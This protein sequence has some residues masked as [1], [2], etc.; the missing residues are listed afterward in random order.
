MTDTE[1]DKAFLNEAQ[2]NLVNAVAELTKLSKSAGCELLLRRGRPK[3]D[4]NGGWKKLPL[5][6]DF[7]LSFRRAISDY[8]TKF[9]SVELTVLAYGATAQGERLG[10]APRAEL[11]EFFEKLPDRKAADPF[12]PDESD[13]SSQDKKC[14]HIGLSEA[15]TLSAFG[16]SGTSEIGRYARSKFLAIWNSKKEVDYPKDELLEIGDKVTFFVFGNFVYVID[17]SGFASATGY[18]DVVKQ[19]S[20]Q[21]LSE[22]DALDFVSFTDR[23]Q[24]ESLIEESPDFAR[25][26]SASSARG[27]IKNLKKEGLE[28]VLRSFAKQLRWEEKDG[29]ILLETKFDSKEQ[30]KAFKQLLGQVFVY[31]A[32]TGAPLLSYSSEPASS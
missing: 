19:R 7:S 30:R 28:S 3:R 29:K 10:V 20:L 11:E 23:A 8:I 17:E 16:P 5:S 9:S 18:Y 6:D 25:R 26:L 2:A 14:V 31:C 24:I 4:Q 1:L 32:A 22:F 13:F 27:F 12:D 21:A 15:Q